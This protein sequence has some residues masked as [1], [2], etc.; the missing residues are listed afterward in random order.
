MLSL[1]D[2]NIGKLVVV[3][4]QQLCYE[5]G[6][7]EEYPNGWTGEVIDVSDRELCARVQFDRHFPPRAREDR[8]KTDEHRSIWIPFAQLARA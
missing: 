7:G 1:V 2:V 4:L 8:R 3:N 5:H 6:G